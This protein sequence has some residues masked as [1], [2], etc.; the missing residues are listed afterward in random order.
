M[1]E[2]VEI[3]HNLEFDQGLSNAITTQAEPTDTQYLLTRSGRTRFTSCRLIICYRRLKKYFWREHIESVHGWMK[4]SRAS[5]AVTPCQHSRILLHLDVRLSLESS[6]SG[7]ISPP[8][9]L[10]V[11]FKRDAI[12]CIHCSSSSS[13]INFSYGCGHIASGDAKLTFPG[14]GS[15]IPGSI[16]L[17]VSFK[18]IQCVRCRENPF[19]STIVKCNACLY[20]YNYSNNPMVRV[21][22]D[23]MKTMIE[24]MFGE[25]IKDYEPDPTC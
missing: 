3:V 13:L 14:P 7:I 4:Q 6:G 22:L 15:P 23:K 19:Y 10:P 8:N 16:D 18:Q 20:P 24:E 2:R 9:M 11:N 5:Q 21:T 1:G 17:L 25:E 12:K